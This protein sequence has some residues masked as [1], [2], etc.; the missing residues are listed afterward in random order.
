M[1]FCYLFFISGKCSGLRKPEFTF[2]LAAGQLRSNYQIC[3]LTLATFWKSES[4]QAETILESESKHVPKSSYLKPQAVS[5][6]LSNSL[7]FS[8]SHGNMHHPQNGILLKNKGIILGDESSLQR[9]R[10]CLNSDASRVVCFRY[11]EILK[12]VVWWEKQKWS[13]WQKF[14]KVQIK[15]IDMEAKQRKKIVEL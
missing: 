12:W 2:P 15:F 8:L 10:P 11:A 3:Q 13:C 1:R 5:C 6:I 7:R 4:H 14:L 9:A